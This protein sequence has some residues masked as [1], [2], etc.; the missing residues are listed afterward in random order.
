M[1]NY[2]FSD[3]FTGEEFI[4]QASNLVNARAIAK[5]YFKEPYCINIL[6]EEHAEMLGLDTY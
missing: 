2:L 3:N 1:K 6:T 5:E 4:V